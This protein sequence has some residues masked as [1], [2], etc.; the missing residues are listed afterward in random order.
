MRASSST[1]S[2]AGSI[3][4]CTCSPITSPNGSSAILLRR[5]PLARGAS[6]AAAIIYDIR[7]RPRSLTRRA[8]RVA[9]RLHLAPRRRPRQRALETAM[10]IDPSPAVDSEG[11]DYFG[12]PVHYLTV[13]EPH[14]QLVVE[15]RSRI[16]VPAVAGAARPRRERAVGSNARHAHGRGRRDAAPG[17]PVRVRLAVLRRERRHSRLRAA[18]VLAGPS[19]ARRRDG[20]HVAHLSRVR[21]PRR[22]VRRFHAVRDVFAMRK[23]VCQDFAHLQIACLRSI[24]IAAR[25]VSGYLLTHPAR[26]QGRSS[27]V[28]THPTRG[29]RSGRRAT[30]GSTSTRPTTR[31]RT[32][33]TSRSDGAATTAT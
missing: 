30:A 26:G 8:S 27:L 12:N 17:L 15:A 29:S 18:V 4:T 3:A 6:I 25:Y 21:I 9:P 24:G 31:S 22:R 23:G 20:P 11:K 14:V 5:G 10:L 33:S 13:Q 1:G 19:R 28:R 2:R 16:D 7:H 32:S